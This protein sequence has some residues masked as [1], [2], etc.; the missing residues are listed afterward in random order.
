[1]TS[2]P[3]SLTAS[4]QGVPPVLYLGDHFG[5]PSGVA[6]G[7][8]TYLLDV[9][10]VLQDAGVTLS[11]CFL[12]E[13]HPAA[14]PLRALGLEPVFLSARP[15]NPLVVF[16]VARV[17]RQARCGMI[18]AAGIKATLVARIVGALL[19]IPVLVHVHDQIMPPRLIRILN[20]L[21][22]RRT[23]YCVGVSAATR[24]VAM[25]GYHVPADRIQVIH[26]GIPLDRVR[27]IPADARQRQRDAV[28]L[29][30]DARL[31]AMVARLHAIK[32]PLPMI[33]MLPKILS[34]C[35]DATLLM[36]GDGPEREACEALAAELGLGARVRFLGHRS[37]V[38]EILAAADLVVMPSVS[39]GLGL[40]AMEA[41]AAGRP[42]VAY[43]VGGLPEVIRDGVDGLCVPAGD[44]SAFAAAVAD[45]LADDARRQRFGASAYEGAERFS[46][47]RHVDAMLECYARVSG[48]RNA[49]PA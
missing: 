48:G 40:A 18:H 23:D 3:G 37:D 35:G 47:N 14:A 36:V 38:P 10:P 22:A 6:H 15:W 45:L 26:N 29:P 49:V 5:Y 19:G 2:L 32:G 27:G 20:R 11:L 25:R 8:T 17:A 34:R 21:F 1:M 43:A 4:S 31:I 33:R 46:L 44:E 24:D 39:E 7:V 42:V 9:L 13:P 30:A 28:A 16:A 41:I 12:R